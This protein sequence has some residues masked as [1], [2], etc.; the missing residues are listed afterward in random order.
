[1][2][3]VY[4]LNTQQSY[5]IDRFVVLITF[6][7][8]TMYIYIFVPRFKGVTQQ[9]L[10]LVSNNF[11]IINYSHDDSILIYSKYFPKYTVLAD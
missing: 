1:M 2:L 6:V 3:I 8:Y 7:T 11:I 9:A 10:A 4:Y 5:N